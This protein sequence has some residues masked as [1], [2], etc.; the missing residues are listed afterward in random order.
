MSEDRD[1]PTFNELTEDQKIPYLVA[2][3]KDVGRR[4]QESVDERDILRAAN[5]S[6]INEN[7]A[8]REA[9]EAVSPWVWDE[10]DSWWICHWCDKISSQALAKDHA[11]DCLYQKALGLAP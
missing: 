6:L 11:E 1:I 7:A 3:C 5:E 8:M 9:L 4:W 2:L 10:T